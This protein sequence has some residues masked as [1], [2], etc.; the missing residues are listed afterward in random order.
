[1][2]TAYTTDQIR[3]AEAALMARSPEG[4]LMERAAAG[5]AAICAR[6]LGRVYGSRVVLL[7]GGGDNGGDALYAGARLASRGARVDAI[8]AGARVHGSELEA[9][10]RAGGRV[11]DLRAATAGGG[12][13]GGI[14]GV[15]VAGELIRA[16]DLVVDGLVGIGGT[17]A[18]REPYATLAGLTAEAAG[19]VVAVDVPSGVDAGSGQVGGAAVRADVTV[20]FGAYKIGL[21]VDPGAEHAGRVEFVDIGLGPHLPGP[22]A[23]ALTGADVALLLPR[24]DAGSDKYSRGVVGVAAGSHQYTGAAVLAVGGAIRAGAGMVRYA[25]VAEPVAQVRARWPEAVITPLEPGEGI[26]EVGRVQAWV[27]GPGLGT[28]PEALAVARSVLASD[29]PVLVDADALTLV[30]RDRS[31][32]RRAAPVLITPHAGELSRLLDVPR[33]RIEARRLEHVRRA[34]AELGVTVLLKGSTTLVAQ[35]G[36]PVRVNL[37]GSPW[38]ATGGTGDVLAGLAGAL[39]AGGL[40]GYDAASCAAHLHGIAGQHGPLAAWDV[41]E[42]LPAVIRSLADRLREGV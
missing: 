16:A 36:R 35:Q 39:L 6:T 18:L 26:E 11:T 10:R 4:A 24:P 13:A 34:A 32:L 42:A 23:T 8:L 3:A 33:A 22:E 29:V 1:M 28:G 15:A 2:L 30:S 27:L 7:I 12:E 19:A 17:G 37:T 20:T 38:L 9:L 14:G 41:V 21:L 40:D 31:L 25:G 5:L